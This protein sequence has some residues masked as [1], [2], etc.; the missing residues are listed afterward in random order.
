MTESRI[1]LPT[2]VLSDS[3]NNRQIGLAGVN[4]LSAGPGSW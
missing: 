4:P 3:K 2:S 1:T